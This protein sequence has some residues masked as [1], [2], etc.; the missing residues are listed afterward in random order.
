[1]TFGGTVVE[2]YVPGAHSMLYFD[3]FIYLFIFINCL[4]YD[5]K[6]FLMMID[7]NSAGSHD[8]ILKKKTWLCFK[9]EESSAKSSVYRID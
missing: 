7:Y 3:N 1:M 9:K 8:I 2:F 5:R 6:K 4:V